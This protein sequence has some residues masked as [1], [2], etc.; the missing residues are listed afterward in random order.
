MTNQTETK[1]TKRQLRSSYITTTISIALVLFLMGIIG[2]LWLNTNRLSKHIKENMGFKVLI[3]NTVKKPEI[4]DLQQRISKA[5]YVKSA[6]YVSK[7][8]ALTIMQ[9]ELGED[10]DFLGVNPL[11]DC[12]EIKL[13]AEYATTERMV[14]I[15]RE[16]Q[17]MP[18]IK[19]VVYKKDLMSIIN[20]NIR[21]ISYVIGSFSLL[22]LLIA[23]A[24]IN[25]TIR[26]S[27][28]AKR[29][30]IRTMQLVG[31]THGYIRRPFLK[32]SL[33]CGLIGAFIAIILLSGL[34]YFSS[35]EV[36]GFIS[37]E[38]YDL[39]SFLFAGVIATGIIISTIS[40][41]FAVN[42]YLNINTDKLYN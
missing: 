1:I 19:E 5:G 20:Q 22:L 14:Q 18:E 30:I 2:L 23:I 8:E 6:T 3:N 24:L 39:I 42:K 26:I 12:I 28:Y 40:T 13:K 41:F 9:N 10:F 17:K 37:F 11:P 38:A 4:L 31:A 25:N 21:K 35:R 29:F 7:E 36:K 32:S 27:I 15:E 34:I 16:L 33:L